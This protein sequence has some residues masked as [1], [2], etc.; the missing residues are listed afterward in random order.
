MGA[1]LPADAMLNE[2]LHA[3]PPSAMPTTRPQQ[4]VEPLLPVGVSADSGGPSLL[5]EGSNVIA[6]KGHLQRSSDSAYSEFVFENAQGEMPLEPMLVLPNLQLMSMESAIAATKQDLLFTVSGVVTECH[7]KNYV[8][9]EPGPDELVLPAVPDTAPK[10]DETKS[11]ATSDDPDKMLDEM[12]AA[13]KKMNAVGAAASTRPSSYTPTTYTPGDM[14]ELAS[15]VAPGPAS[16]NLL[17]ERSWIMDR[18]GRLQRTQDGRYEEIVFDAD[19]SAL[20][21]PPIIILPNLKLQALEAAAGGDN[22]DPR[23]MVTGTVTEYRGKNYILLQK[24]V[25]M[26]LS[27]RE[28]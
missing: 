20:Q 4:N 8:L 6:R 10:P 25:V 5:R 17:R 21:D 9:L 27:A 1:S 7:A 15:S 13:T 11:D 22:H 26:P 16:T 12:L 2:M 28:F 18:A 23:F 14:G 3:T 19:G 24:V